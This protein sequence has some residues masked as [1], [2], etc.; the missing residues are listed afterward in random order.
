MGDFNS[1]DKLDLAT[2]NQEPSTV[3]ILLGN[4]DGTFVGV[5]E[6]ILRD[7][8]FSITAGHFNGDGN[9]DLATADINSNVLLLLG[10]GNGTFQSPQGFTVGNDTSSITV[11]DFNGDGNQDLATA[12]I[13][14]L[15]TPV[16]FGR[17]L[18]SVSILLGN[19]N[20]SF[21]SAPE[22]IGGSDEVTVGDFNGDGRLDLATAKGFFETVSILLGDG[23]GSFRPAQDFRVE[24]APSSVTVGDF[25]D[26]GNQIS[27][28]P[29]PV[30]FS[31][32]EASLSCWATAMAPS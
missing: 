9:Q 17:S 3:S 31:R 26:D 20:G 19:D 24:G 11:G 2:T 7:D 30:T 6:V 22:A 14:S 29:F 18:G 13:L 28:Q 5:Q 16:F 4:G 25:N 1:D 21:L 8:F 10:N 15:F 27:P 12:N 23:D 32:P